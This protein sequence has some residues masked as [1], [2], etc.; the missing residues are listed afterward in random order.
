MLRFHL[1]IFTIA[2]AL[3]PTAIAQKT[4]VVFV[5][6]P[7]TSPS[8]NAAIQQQAAATDHSASAVALVQ[9]SSATFA[10]LIS[11]TTP[12]LTSTMLQP[13][14]TQTPSSTTSQF[15]AGSEYNAPGAPGAANSG[16]DTALGASGSDASSFNL[17]KGALAGIIVVVVLAALFG[18]T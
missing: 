3:A 10:T 11:S 4:V 16:A 2:L 7:P 8:S 12:S 15:D 18:S 6:V 13:N 17:S 14:P 5:T 9:S 1:L